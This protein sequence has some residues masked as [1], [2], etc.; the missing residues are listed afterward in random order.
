MLG[1]FDCFFFVSLLFGC[2]GIFGFRFFGDMGCIGR[3][4]G[5]LCEFELGVVFWSCRF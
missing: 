5:L 3:V 2:M 4:L 1:V